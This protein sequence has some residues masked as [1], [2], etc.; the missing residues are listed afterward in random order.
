MSHDI[1]AA[2]DLLLSRN[3]VEDMQAATKDYTDR[4]IAAISQADGLKTNVQIV[5][6]GSVVK[7]DIAT[8][9]SYSRTT[10]PTS[11]AVK[12]NIDSRGNSTP[13][14]AFFRVGRHNQLA[15][16]ASAIPGDMAFVAVYG[17]E[18]AKAGLY[19]L[20]Q[21]PPAILGNWLQVSLLIW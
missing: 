12:S 15:S 20:V 21:S 9:L 17:T 18:G 11:Q 6:L 16:L 10:V 5:G 8:E 14:L 19:I 2:S 3:P 1:T 7:Y 4:Q 13:R